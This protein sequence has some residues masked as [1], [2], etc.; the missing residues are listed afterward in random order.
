M[1]GIVRKELAHVL[2]RRG[3]RHREWAVEWES[4]A[5][6]FLLDK[7][8]S[9]A[10]GARPLKRAID[11]HLLAP[12]AAALVQHRFPEGDQFLFVRS[13]GKALQVEFVDPYASAESG[14]LKDQEAAATWGTPATLPTMMLRSSGTPA[15]HD[16]LLAEMG[17]LDADW[18]TID[19]RLYRSNLPRTC[20][21]LTSGIV[22]IGNRR[23]PGSRSWIA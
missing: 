5:L 21:I 10:M 2:E 13:D 7:G 3:L 15:E 9:P 19:G 8:F 11:Q 20:S 23:S 4:S 17:R 18:Q 6:E 22:Q 14:A 16:A 12:L 1:R